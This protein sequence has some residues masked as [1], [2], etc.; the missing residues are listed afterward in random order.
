[1]AS[2]SD[3]KNTRSG[4][5]HKLHKPSTDFKTYRDIAPEAVTDDTLHELIRRLNR[6]DVKIRLAIQELWNDIPD[7]R[8][9]AP[10]WEQS[11]KKSKKKQDGPGES[12]GRGGR[13]RG[14]SQPPGGRGG[15][16]GRGSGAARSTSVNSTSRE[17]SNKPANVNNTAST[18]NVNSNQATQPPAEGQRVNAKASLGNTV[19]WGAGLNLAEKIKQSE[20]QKRLAQELAE[21]E[22]AEKQYEGELEQQYLD[23]N[24]YQDEILEED[25]Q[26][27]EEEE[28]VE[29]ANNL[30]G[31]TLSES[32]SVQASVVYQEEII[33]VT[34]QTQEVHD[35]NSS[36]K[37]DQTSSTFLKLG[38]W[39]NQAPVA[40]ASSFQFGS[41]GSFGRA[42]N[43]NPNAWGTQ[44][45]SLE[46]SREVQ[47]EVTHQQVTWNNTSAQSTTLTSTSHHE[48]LLEE[49][50]VYNYGGHKGGN[51]SQES[52][53]QQQG[54]SR[55]PETSKQ[56]GTPPPGLGNDLSKPSGQQN[57]HQGGRKGNEGVNQQYQY[58][59]PQANVN[60]PPGI[61]HPGG[62]GNQQQQ[63]NIGMMPYGMY[64]Y[65][66]QPG[67]IYPGYGL[68]NA[69][70]NP[71]PAANQTAAPA[72]NAANT[73]ANTQQQT[74][75]QQQQGVQG[76]PPGMQ[77][78]YPPQA[79]YNMYYGQYY[80]NGQNP[81][82]YRQNMYQPPRV[83][84]GADPYGYGDMYA[85]TGQYP[86]SGYVQMHQGQQSGAAGSEGQSRG[87]KNSKNQGNANQQQG[88]DMSQ[89]Y[90]Q[91]YPN[92]WY[93]QQ[94]QWQ[95]QYPQNSPNSQ[96]YS[97][98]SQQSSRSNYNRNNA[99]ANN[100]P[101]NASA[102]QQ[103]W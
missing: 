86:D 46:S 40:E 82:Y 24:N 16:A 67:Y 38:K 65:E 36:S 37:V 99:N 94:S 8:A 93:Q 59:Y 54:Q 68:P 60:A 72:G 33:S 77:M 1:M 20:E 39:E 89:H 87:G 26:Q 43:A 42:D 7:S 95:G 3:N 74:Q 12:G 5:S 100:N 55:Y 34:S 29:F 47:S 17:G 13:G 56:S 102:G 97:Q 19:V 31:L 23:D 21:R 92:M 69:P 70:V 14:R 88:A 61:Q 62:K 81:N 83:P 63:Q 45:V 32:S 75:Q 73:A 98:G 51:N 91:Q 44:Q 66:G 22:A 4:G 71:A 35:A 80:Y 49:S 96:G 78:P 64:G 2:R 28:A 48:E 30:N 41:F 15:G 25:N 79:Y 11:G 50:N 57:R 53:I 10:E 84:Y 6:D 85:Q 90:M 101:A 76:Y 58:Q 52:I 9:N 103:G 18:E 27:P